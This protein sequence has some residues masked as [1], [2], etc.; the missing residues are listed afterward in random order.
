MSSVRDGHQ[1]PDALF[2]NRMVAGTAIGLNALILGAFTRWDSRPIAFPP[3][4][5]MYVSASRQRFVIPR[6]FVRWGASL[7]AFAAAATAALV[8]V[9]TLSAAGMLA[10]IDRDVLT[11]GLEIALLSAFAAIIGGLLVGIVLNGYLPSLL[12]PR[13]RPGMPAFGALLRGSVTSR[14]VFAFWLSAVAAFL[15]I[16]LVQQPMGWLPNIAL[17]LSTATLL[18]LVTLR[19]RRFW[20]TAGRAPLYAG[21][22][23]SEL[24]DLF[25]ATRFD[26]RSEWEPVGGI[27][28]AERAEAYRQLARGKH[29]S[30]R[31]LSALITAAAGTAIA[32]AVSWVFVDPS[33]LSMAVA[34]IPFFALLVAQFM[35][36]LSEQYDALSDQYAERGVELV[37]AA[38]VPVLQPRWRRLREVASFAA[39]VRKS[40]IEP[41]R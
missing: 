28:S 2:S 4:R 27:L 5:D 38:A 36:V 1:S 3:W 21:L 15:S 24:G 12:H 34:I 35:Q 37:S 20:R 40:L 16:S 41:H 9:P 22:S 10:L 8:M 6:S 26:D 30:L 39:T 18:V 7:G 14:L 32:A 23:D 29:L 17:T 25:Q 33:G 13:P 19:Y 11:S 31:L